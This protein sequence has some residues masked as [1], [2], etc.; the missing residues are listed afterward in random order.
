MA[1]VSHLVPGGSPMLLRQHNLNFIPVLRELLRTQSVGATAEVVGL[2]P[3]GVSAAL[4]RL[5]ETFD[6]E[7][8]IPMGR[9]LRLT[10]KGRALIEQT[11]RVCADMELLLRPSRFDPCNAENTFIVA[12]ADY[13]SFMLAPRV[14]DLLGREA[15]NVGVRFM[16]IPTDYREGL[17]RG[18]LDFVVV[19]RG[20]AQD[21]AP[22]TVST[23]F[24]TDN[25]V[26]I[27]SRRHRGFK[28][29]L[30][31]A[32]YESCPH[33][34]FQMQSRSRVADHEALALSALG[35]RQ[36][37]RVT[38]QQFLA[39]PAIVQDTD[40]LALVQ[41]RLADAFRKSYEIDVFPPPFDMP[42]LELTAHWRRVTES[43]PASIWFRDLMRRALPA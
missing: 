2:S 12:T 6:D 8:L 18:A 29:T 17:G 28:S 43:D 26:V 30:T 10:Q 21:L 3:S 20:P 4:A 37:N 39:L 33:A 7:L 5:R 9:S 36:K 16:D 14:A 13:V 32:T 23:L 19:S 1:Q 24:L 22:S 15:P 40:C 35:I 34:A 41:R 25:M 38:V 42:P 27:A 11:E 31:R